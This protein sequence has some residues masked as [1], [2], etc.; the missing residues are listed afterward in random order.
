MKKFFILLLIIPFCS[1]AQNYPYFQPKEFSIYKQTIQYPTY[2][3]KDSKNL[4]ASLNQHPGTISSLKNQF[5]LTQKLDS[6]YYYFWNT[7]SEEWT[8]YSKSHKYL[9]NGSYKVISFEEQEWD[10]TSWLNTYQYNYTYDV[11]QNVISYNYKTWKGNTWENEFQELISYNSINNETYMLSQNWYN[12]SWVNSDQ[13]FTAY[14][15][16]QNKTSQVLQYWNGEHW[17]NLRRSIY[18][19][20]QNNDLT[21]YLSQGWD[22]NNQEWE[23]DHQILDSFDINHHRLSSTNQ[24]WNSLAWKNALRELFYFDNDYNIIGYL[25]LDWDG[26]QWVND[27]KYENTFDGNNNLIAVFSQY[28]AMSKWKNSIRTTNNYNTHNQLIRSFDESWYNNSW[29]MLR[30]NLESY[31]HDKFMTGQSYKEF[32]EPNQYIVYGDSTQYFFTTITDV[33]ELSGDPDMI[34]Y[35]N[36]NE[37]N[38]IMSSTLPIEAVSAYNLLGEQVFNKKV[39]NEELTIEFNLTTLPKGMYVVIAKQGNRILQRKVLIQ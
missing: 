21:Y 16:N 15:A 35:P 27:Y 38:F 10:G 37:G 34:L 9:Y 18:S 2:Q 22:S 1:Q 36:P 39:N 32:D 24:S 28:W 11:N 14:D 20:N 30:E 6:I 17:S 3:L 26:I 29:V 5:E 33:E 23:N 4:A 19:Y 7:T 12:N 8:I 25:R 31:N 13:T